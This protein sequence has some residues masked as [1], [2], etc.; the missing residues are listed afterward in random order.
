MTAT[1]NADKLL[2]NWVSILSQTHHTQNLLFDNENWSGLTDD[3]QQQEREAALEE[4]RRHEQ[5]L[6]EQRE[7]EERERE[8]LRRELE[9]EQREKDNAERQKVDEA[10]KLREE[11]E[12]KRREALYGYRKP[13]PL[14]VQ[15]SAASTVAASSRSVPKG[16]GTLQES[17]RK[18][19]GQHDSL[20][21]QR[22]GGTINKSR[23][24]VRAGHGNGDSS[25]KNNDTSDSR[26]LDSSLKKNE[27]QLSRASS[28]FK[29]RPSRIPTQSHAKR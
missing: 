28:R 10:R 3:I 20:A 24:A 13:P 25:F 7:E 26:D 8:R 2:S 21:S 4:E 14:R 9:R 6:R 1:Q 18:G 27:S 16:S 12:R 15:P 17:T 23:T 29:P 5:E 11:K 19:V 22:N